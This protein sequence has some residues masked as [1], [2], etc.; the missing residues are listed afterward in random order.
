M[1]NALPLEVPILVEIGIGENW[2]AAH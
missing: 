2:L 1:K